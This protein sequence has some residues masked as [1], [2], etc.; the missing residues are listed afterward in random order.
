[1]TT[2]IVADHFFYADVYGKLFVAD[3]VQKV[4][5]M[6]EDYEVM[7]RRNAPLLHYIVEEQTQNG[8]FLS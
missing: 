6:V 3:T 4:H 8:T 1:M 7:E 5:I 2:V